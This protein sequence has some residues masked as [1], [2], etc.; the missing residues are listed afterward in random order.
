MGWL[1]TLKGNSSDKASVHDQMDNGAANG[2]LEARVP[3][4][5]YTGRLVLGRL[6]LALLWKRNQ[7][8]NPC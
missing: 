5:F 4:L 8:K 6:V 7:H 2:R 3:F 1:Q